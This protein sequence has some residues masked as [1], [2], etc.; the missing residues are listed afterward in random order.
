VL[1][2]RDM[3]KEVKDGL[4]EAFPDLKKKRFWFG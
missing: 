1:G 2:D 4:K 3:P